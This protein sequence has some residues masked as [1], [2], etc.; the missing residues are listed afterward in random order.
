[1]GATI[2]FFAAV[3]QGAE[4]FEDEI[5]LH[6]CCEVLVTTEMS[7]NRHQKRFWKLW[8]EGWNFA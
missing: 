6:L 8:T 3:K 1:M 2:F 5:F 4:T 7:S